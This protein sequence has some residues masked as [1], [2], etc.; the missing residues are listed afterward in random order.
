VSCL[1]PS[2]RTE[3][4]AGLSFCFCFCA[5]TWTVIP[6]PLFLPSDS[7]F[8]S[9]RLSTPVAKMLSRSSQRTAQV[10]DFAVH[11]PMAFNA[12]IHEAN[13]T[14]S[15]DPPAGRQLANRCWSID[16][17]EMLDTIIVANCYP[18]I[19]VCDSS[20]HHPARHLQANQV[21]WQVHRYPHPR[22]ADP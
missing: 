11:R 8:T 9:S 1:R 18:V 12:Q 13:L 17:H 15:A 4:P 20:G 16:E 19:D 10:S 5:Q 6:Q 22:L 3:I 14:S 2:L 7:F 21:R